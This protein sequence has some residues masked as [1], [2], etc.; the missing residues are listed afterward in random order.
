VLVCT[1]ALPAIA[2]AFRVVDRGGTILLFAPGSPGVTF[3]LPLYDLWKDGITILHS[4]AGPPAD[5]VMARDLIATKRVDVAAMVT[6]RLPLAE[7]GKGFRTVVE[8]A[9]S[10]KVIVEPQH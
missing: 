1:A 8:A 5:I 9:R 6:D 10:L 3:P 7:T 4:Y 2:Q